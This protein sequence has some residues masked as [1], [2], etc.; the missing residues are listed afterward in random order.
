MLIDNLIAVV[1][2][3]CFTFASLRRRNK[4]VDFMKYLF[5]WKNSDS[6]NVKNPRFKNNENS[7]A[8]NNM[9]RNIC[10]TI[11]HLLIVLACVSVL[12]PFILSDSAKN[13]TEVDSWRVLFL[14][15]GITIIIFKGKDI[16]G[17]LK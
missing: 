7:Q 2:A 5:S 3:F 15:V 14:T 8:K 6:N 4:P 10:N 17:I 1:A 9:C 11:C 12:S 13:F 16:R